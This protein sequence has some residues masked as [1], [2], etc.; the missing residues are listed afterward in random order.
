MKKCTQC[1]KLTDNFSR[2]VTA[3]DD[4][5][6]VCRKCNAKNI[7]AFRK[8]R[9]GIVASIFQHQKSHSKRRGHAE[10]EYS[11]E[12]LEE[13]MFSQEGFE[14]LYNDWCE[15]GFKTKDKPSIDRIDNEKG[16]SFDNIQLTTWEGNLRNEARDIVQGK[17]YNGHKR[18][19]QY[20]LS[21][22][23]VAEYFSVAQA[24]RETGICDRSLAACCRKEPH[25]LTAGGFKWEYI[26]STINE[27]K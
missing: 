20:N 23:L 24:S 3:K 25:R 5:Q 4:L 19:A 22:S 9:K 15:G 7:S 1:T 8:T 11:Q 2:N 27:L 10:P 17:L 16:Y 6:S 12:A 18:V 26:Q 13:W 14:G 21:G